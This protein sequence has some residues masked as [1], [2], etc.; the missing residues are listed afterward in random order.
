VAGEV[1][2]DGPFAEFDRLIGRIGDPFKAFGVR[3]HLLAA[4]VK[5]L[6]RRGFD[7]GVSPY[8]GPW[9]GRKR[10][11]RN[12]M[13]VKSGATRNADVW[14]DNGDKA[15]RISSTPWARYHQF[16]KSGRV[17]NRPMMPFE[18]ASSWNEPMFEQMLR[19][20]QMYFEAD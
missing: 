10:N 4:E 2:V 7:Q 12:P 18:Y 11:Q 14:Y 3:G 17:P 1:D 5:Q 6:Y 20:L 9:A 13:M 16:G 8:G 19:I 15:V